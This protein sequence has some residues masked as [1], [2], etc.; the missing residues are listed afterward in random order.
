MQFTAFST[1]TC[2]TSVL[3]FIKAFKLSCSLEHYVS[4]ISW[5]AESSELHLVFMKNL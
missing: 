4:E 2:K 1:I 5:C 3:A